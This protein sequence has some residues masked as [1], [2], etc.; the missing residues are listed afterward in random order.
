MSTKT[1]PFSFLRFRMSPFTG[2]S[3]FA[4]LW[5]AGLL[6]LMAALAAGLFRDQPRVAAGNAS[7]QAKA[8]ITFRKQA[9]SSE[10]YESVGVADVNGDGK[11]DLLSGCFW[12]E[13]PEFRKF[14]YIG[15][16]KRY[17]EYWDDFSTIFMD[18][19]GD[20]RPDFVTGG[21]FGQNIRWR[22]NPGNDKEWPEHI[23][24]ETGNVECTRAW[25]VDG[26]GFAEICPNN[27]GKPLAFYRLE[28][29]AQKKPLGTFTKVS[30][31]PS[32]GHGLGFGD[33]NG[34]GRGDFIVSN[35]WLEAP[36]KPL[37]GNWTHRPEFDLG[38]ASVPVLVTDIN[39]DG[40][41]DVI[42]GQGHSYGLHW[43][44]QQYN[45]ANKQRTWKKHTIDSTGSQFHTMEWVDLDGD[46]KSELLTGK[47]YRAHN[48]RDPGEFDDLGL[49]YYAWNGKSFTKNVISYGP[50]GSGKGTG[51]YMAVA[52]LRGTG[53]K[54]I[55]VAGKD[56][57]YVFF[58]EG[59]RTSP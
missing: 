55:V 56:G 17:G 49:Y 37:E 34:D 20:S 22:E 12:Y 1:F 46:G 31:A 13:G 39:G 52:D 43:Y 2:R 50:Y 41:N 4:L 15:E 29:D 24:A 25:D 48:G 35:G 45:K 33:V 9:V 3:R 11:P 7:A 47:R 18:I 54:D 6:L 16:V 30:V 8:S 19:N 23:I 53:R 28:R 57:L 44:E 32:Q 42:A 36:P 58:N 51:I 5:S 14:H 27:P 38:T 59:I 10:S 21:W 40:K 26:D